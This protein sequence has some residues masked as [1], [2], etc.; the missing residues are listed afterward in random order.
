MLQCEEKT[1]KAAVATTSISKEQRIRR[2]INVY[3]SFFWTEFISSIPIP[4]EL[5]KTVPRY[6]LFQKVALTEIGLNIKLPRKQ[7]D[8]DSGNPQK[9]KKLGK[10]FENKI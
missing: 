2:G 3:L 4:F 6:L 9:S 5:N 7:A 10:E 8:V 1:L